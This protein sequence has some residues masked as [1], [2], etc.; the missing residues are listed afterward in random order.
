[1]DVDQRSRTK[2][3]SQEEYLVDDPFLKWVRPTKEALERHLAIAMAKDDDGSLFPDI[4]HLK[5]LENSYTA[6]AGDI[7]SGR[8][9]TIILSKLPN[10]SMVMDGIKI[11]AGRDGLEGAPQWVQMA[12]E[13]SRRQEGGKQDMVSLMRGWRNEVQVDVKLD[14]I[15][16]AALG[17]D[18]EP[19]GTAASLEDAEALRE[20]FQKPFLGSADQMLRLH[21]ERHMGKGGNR[22]MV[23]ANVI[24]ILQSS[25]FGKSKTVTQLSATNLGLFVCVRAA[26]LNRVSQPPAD[27]SVLPFL[28]EDL[29]SRG[30]LTVFRKTRI[31]AV[32]LIA[33][34]EEMASFY[35]KEWKKFQEE[36]GDDRAAFITHVGD[37]LS[38]SQ[39]PL[40][41][42]STPPRRK[43]STSS[44]VNHRDRVLNAIAEK[45]TALRKESRYSTAA[46][47]RRR[48]KR[49]SGRKRK[50]DDST[51]SASFDI[52]EDPGMTSDDT[53]YVKARPAPSNVSG[54]LADEAQLDPEELSRYSATAEFFQTDLHKAFAHL[55]SC[56]P[57]EPRGSDSERKYF[58][59][60]AIDE[61]GKM[62]SRLAVI[63]RLWSLIGVSRCFLFLLDTNTQISLTYGQESVDSSL[64]L[65]TGEKALLPPF[66]RLPQDLA[67]RQDISSYLQMVNGD[68][69]VSHNDVSAWLPKMGRPLL[70]D[71][72]LLRSLAGKPNLAKLS[73]KLLSDPVVE[74]FSKIQPSIA[75]A[76]HRMSLSLVGKQGGQEMNP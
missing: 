13:R 38:P 75:L 33:M 15:L 52:K 1:M 71:K 76:L 9:E 54:G 47:D 41:R 23:Y 73:G 29:S 55:E 7:A 34:A 67:L 35:T 8:S 12:G 6:L 70:N 46:Y 65:K 32:W 21:V 14:D 3:L 66:T 50:A 48:R 36:H 72:W 69:I 26:T 5:S 64:R 17:S 68:T 40:S 59:H 10:A 2:R 11:I 57:E 51:S 4:Q 63:R 37:V 39:A 27:S 30:H 53:E 74:P 42:G 61:C 22:A 19:K 45:A 60:L 16:R 25:G 31:V 58:F 24:P 43:T 49:D 28:Q 44:S 62:A 18:P 20:D 56:L